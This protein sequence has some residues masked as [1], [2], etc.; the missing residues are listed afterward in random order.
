MSRKTHSL[1][2]LLQLSKS[3]ADGQVR[4]PLGLWRDGSA[5][6]STD[7]WRSKRIPG[8]NDLGI[9]TGGRVHILPAY[10]TLSPCQ[11]MMGI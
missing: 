7:C 10:C 11:L 1:A 2:V 9:L 3:D 5:Y 8:Q 6:A 4:R